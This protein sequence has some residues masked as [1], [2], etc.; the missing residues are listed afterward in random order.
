MCPVVFCE[1]T[2]RERERQR[3]KGGDERRWLPV[4]G[5]RWRS[6]ISSGVKQTGDVVGVNRIGK[7]INAA[8]SHANADTC[9]GGGGGKRRKT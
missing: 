2:E 4:V 6:A 7:L 8:R 5:E 3:K 9:S 1:V